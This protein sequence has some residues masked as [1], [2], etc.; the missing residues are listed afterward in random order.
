MISFDEITSRAQ[1]MAQ[2]DY[3]EF[4]RHTMPSYD[5]APH[6]L[7]HLVPI[8]YKAML[9][10]NY[11][12]IVTLPPRHSKSLNVSE[13][14]PPFYLGLFPQNRIIAASHTGS[15]ANTFSRRVRNTIQ[16]PRYPFEH[17]QV[18]DDKGAVQ[19]WDVT[20][21]GEQAGG[22]YAVGVG[23]TPTGQ[24]ANLIIIDDPIRS[25]ADADSEVV[26]QGI[27]TWFTETMYTR[28]EPGGSI[29]ITATR[30]HEDDLTGRLLK[31]MKEGGEEWE[32][33][34]LPAINEEGEPLWPTRWP[35][36][37]LLRIQRAVGSRAW[38]AQ[39]QGS[40]VLESGSIIKKHWLLPYDVRPHNLRV[41]QSWDTA[42]ETASHNDYSV[43]TTIAYNAYE[44]YIIDVYRE[45]LEF[46]DLKRMVRSQFMKFRPQAILMENAAS[47]RSIIQDNNDQRGLNFER[48]PIIPV[49][50]PT[51]KN[52]KQVRVQ[53]LTPMLESGRVRVPQ[54]A[55]WLEDWMNEIT[56]FPLA[57]HDDQVDSMAQ[58]LYY[59]ENEH[60]TGLSE[61]SWLPDVEDDDD[62]DYYDRRFS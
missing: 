51:I 61:G 45:K 62:D 57:A 11:R 59:L 18:A 3:I 31:Q 14:M 40:P 23:G 1:Q 6:I 24:G 53:E 52:W 35:L 44:R 33:T 16:S 39:Y 20:Y 30:W 4:C 10:P 26:R 47:G 32:H 19:A 50:V 7:D 37:S 58:G 43:C 38:S 49:D 34:H 9:T 5:A 17:V 21:K 41:I 54:E 46:P 2:E 60:K 15:L 8:I 22:Y 48:L 42:Y 12:G 13:K 56:R 36:R 55:T 29:L 25:A 28:L 27:W